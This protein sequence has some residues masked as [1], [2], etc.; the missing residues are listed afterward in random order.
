MS[1]SAAV[2]Q[3]PVSQSESIY[4]G[5]PL[6][7]RADLFER[8]RNALISCYFTRLDPLCR[9]VGLSTHAA[10]LCQRGAHRRD[11]IEDDS[12]SDVILYQ[13]TLGTRCLADAR[14][15]VDFQGLRK[16]TSTRWV[17]ENRHSYLLAMS[18]TKRLAHSQLRYRV[19]LAESMGL[20][21]EGA[22]SVLLCTFVADS[23][24][25]KSHTLKDPYPTC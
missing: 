17:S 23:R 24:H 18:T 4:H 6:Y 14:R 20:R 16:P 12:A 13:A 7:F 9:P 19:R 10:M 25:F 5:L 1:V 3:P 21:G 15:T 22:R 8:L 11:F 2:K